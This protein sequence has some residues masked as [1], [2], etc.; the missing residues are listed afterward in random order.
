MRTQHE[1][2]LFIDHRA[3]PGLPGTPALQEMATLRC[4]H[5]GGVQI[6][7]HDRVRPREA[8]MKCGGAYICDGCHAATTAPLYIHRSF[9]QIADMVRSGRF[10]LS[11]SCS[12]PILTPK[13]V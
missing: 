8:C 9:D 10:E 1:G 12:F 13:G 3:S 6:K 4:V 5:C 2:Y 11:G 7:R